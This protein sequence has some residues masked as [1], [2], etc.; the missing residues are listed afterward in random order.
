M[1]AE[2]QGFVRDLHDIAVNAFARGAQVPDVRRP[3][4]VHAATS[5]RKLDL[6]NAG[7]REIKLD[8][9]RLGFVSLGA[10]LAE[11]NRNHAADKARY[12]QLTVLR[13]ALAHGNAIQLRSLAAEEIKPTMTWGRSVLPPLNRMAGALDRSVWN[14]A[15]KSYP[16]I[17]PWGPT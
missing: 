15:R 13:N 12:E 6:G 2:F 14:H 8:F 16:S 4:V 1:Y 9:Q 5:G 17:D 3:P 10:E 11:Q 7:L